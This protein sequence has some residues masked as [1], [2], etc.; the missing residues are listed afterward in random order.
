MNNLILITSVI[1]TPNTP[2]SYTNTRS[3]FSRQ[4]R[5]EQTKKTIKSVR[6]KLSNSKIIIVE[7]SDFNEEENNYFKENCDYKL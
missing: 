2:L 6:E 3:V 1:N 5:F 4:D 7:C